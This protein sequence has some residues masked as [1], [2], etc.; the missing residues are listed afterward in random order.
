ML[1]ED[2][3]HRKGQLLE[4]EIDRL[5]ALA[6]QSQ[7]HPSD[8]LLLH[9]NGNY[10]AEE[11]SYGGIKMSPFIIGP[12][13]IGWAYFTH[14]HFINQ[15]RSVA[16]SKPSLTE[17]L[18]TLQEM[19]NKQQTEERDRLLANEDLSIHLETLI[20][21]KVWESDFVLKRFYEFVRILRGLSY[22]WYFKIAESSRDAEATG[23]THEIIRKKIRDKLKDLS[24]VLYDSFSVS[25]KSQIRNSIAH[26]NFSLQGRYIQLNNYLASDPASPLHAIP[27]DEWADIFHTTL[28]LYN[29]M[30]GLDHRIQAHYHEVATQNGNELSILIRDTRNGGSEYE[31]TLTY[32]P[33]FQDYHF[34][35]K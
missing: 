32:R 17:Y 29:M 20:Y 12:D 10:R 22:D 35:Q 1:F 34:K 18:A 16:A 27:Y 28:M 11:V 2:L 19:L 6:L 26:S 3:I 7:Q 24:P 9:L 30:I 33:E 31:V 25:Y 4:T 8:L 23:V 13:R 14:Y 21:L 15:Y 5:F